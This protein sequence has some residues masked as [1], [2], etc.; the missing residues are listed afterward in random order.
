MV[1]LHSISR[2]SLREAGEKHLDGAP[3]SYLIY[4]FIFDSKCEIRGLKKGIWYNFSQEPFSIKKCLD[5]ILFNVLCFYRDKLSFCTSCEI[6]ITING[7]C[8][9]E[10]V[11]IQ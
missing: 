2:T 3:S 8:S 7:G 6:C 5:G 4:L 9:A 10:L 1:T 11:E